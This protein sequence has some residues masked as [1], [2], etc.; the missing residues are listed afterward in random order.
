MPGALILFFNVIACYLFDL[1]L[2]T[3]GQ[4]TTMA[5]LA[6]TFVGL[7]VLFRLCKPFDVYRGIMYSCMVALVAVVLAVPGWANFFEYIP[8]SIQNILFIVCIV[9]ASYPCYDAIVKGLD[10]MIYAGQKKE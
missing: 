5:S 2:G 6:I 8:L 1:G 9:E 3:D 7:L 4:F 10:K